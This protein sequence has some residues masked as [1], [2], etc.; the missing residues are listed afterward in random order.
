MVFILPR[1]CMVG[2]QYHKSSLI[3]C[4]YRLVREYPW[5]CM[6]PCNPF[7]LCLVTCSLGSSV[8]CSTTL[9]SN[10]YTALVKWLVVL[11]VVICLSVCRHKKTP[12]LPI[13]AALLVLNTFKPCKMLKNCLVCLLGTLYKHL[14]PVFWV[15]IMGT[16]TDHTQIPCHVL[17][18]NVRWQFQ[19]S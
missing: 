3:T 7:I 11:S 14:N 8:D 12:V 5:P 4:G 13:Q 17:M 9:S 1:M 10:I 2:G 18:Y 19:C 6:K 16:P 15:G